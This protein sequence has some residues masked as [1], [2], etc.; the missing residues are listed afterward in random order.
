MD[1]CTS[2]VNEGSVVGEAN[3]EQSSS[4]PRA[5]SFNRGRTNKATTVAATGR[6]V[7]PHARQ[8]NNVS[9]NRCCKPNSDI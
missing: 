7:N 5:E 3:L 1:E 2:S 6:T 4:A 9:M 8:R